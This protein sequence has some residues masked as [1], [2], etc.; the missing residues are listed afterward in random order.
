MLKKSGFLTMLM[1]LP[2]LASGQGSIQGLV[3][4]SGSNGNIISLSAGTPTSTFTLTLPPS[5]PS[6]GSLLYGS[7]TGQMQWNTTLPTDAGYVLQLQSI[8]GVLMPKWVDPMSL[9]GTYVNYN[10]NSSQATSVLHSN[11]LFNVSY[12][13]AAD[14]AHA[15]GARIASTGGL[16]NRNATGLTLEATASGLGMATGLS[17]AATG[18]AQNNAIDATGTLRLLASGGTS[19]RLVL[20]N[21]A[22]TFTSS[23]A[24][25]AQTA[26]ISYTLPTT[27][28]AINGYI[29]SANTSGVLS[30]TDPA[31][32]ASGTYWTLAG[33]ATT[34]SWDGTDG[35]FLGTTGSEPLVM[36]TQDS[37][38]IKIITD[39]TEHVRVLANGNIGIGNTDP[40]M[41]LD[42]TG[43]FGT[44]P[45]NVTLSNGANHNINIGNSSYVRITGPTAAF[46][47]SG[48]TP[49]FD[50]K[51]VRIVNTTGQDWTVTNLDASS[52]AGNRILTNTQSSITI[53][54]PMPVLEMIF[55]GGT[56][57]WLLGTLNA[58]Q[59]VGAVGSIIYARKTATESITNSTTLQD[60]D[61]LS[62]AMNANETWEIN[63][64]L[65]A[66]INASSTQ[67]IRM[68]L[69]IPTG[70]TMRVMYTAIANAGGNAITGC[71]LITTSNASTDIA[72]LSPIK[73]SLISIRGI[74]IMGS[75]SG[76]VKLRWCQTS[77]STN[78]V[79][80]ES[81]SY[82][83][84]MRT[85]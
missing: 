52:S 82:M 18:G 78:S 40:L 6:S 59:V 57:Q 85:E 29:L 53:R 36:G 77:S 10:T 20:Q 51:R 4:I 21:P 2:L 13:G 44:R 54:G 49:G 71:E 73:H 28:P 34:S 23:F 39:N 70:A 32:V 24:A 45:T 41:P 38:D 76:S 9:I 68:A 84:I 19:S 33:N 83:K 63:G 1:L 66:S 46:S 25:G 26:N 7:G 67:G 15:V 43:A 55:D 61:H 27:A 30:W 3:R 8:A 35:S 80:I 64:E 12:D 58:N 50:G 79:S 72:I 48:L 74:I 81:G 11:Y 14:D 42:I 37:T 69:E 75:T 62:F 47:M 31:I 5:L 65:D 17:V 16:T 60:D 22:G 56:N